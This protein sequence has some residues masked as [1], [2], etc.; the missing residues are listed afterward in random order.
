LDSPGGALKEGCAAVNNDA[1][2]KPTQPGQ[3]AAGCF[4]PAVGQHLEGIMETLPKTDVEIGS[5][6][7]LGFPTNGERDNVTYTQHIRPKIFVPNHMTAVALESSSLRWKVG[8]LQQEDAMKIP[9]D[10]RPE[11]RWLVDP[12]DYLRPLVFDPKDKR[13]GHS[14]GD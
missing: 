10:Q 13:W 2:G 6:V 9:A 11:L 7:S 5:I 4:G 12:D 1:N 8:F 3:D 14:D